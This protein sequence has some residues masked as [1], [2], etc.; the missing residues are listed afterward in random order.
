MKNYLTRQKKLILALNN[1]KNFFLNN[2]F[3]LS[4]I[5]A[6]SLSF[7][8]Y[9]GFR[10]VFPIDSFLIF[11]SG[12]NVSNNIHP[13]KDYW[14]ITGPV[15]D[16]L[17]A[18]FFFIFGFN[19]HSYVLHA[20]ILNTILSIS[21]FY[22]FKSFNVNIFFSTIFAISVGIL[23]YPSIGT[24]FVD[25]H[26]TIFCTLSVSFAILGLINNKSK[27]W[28][29]SSL[30]IVLAFF[31]KQVPSAY[32]LIF[33]ISTLF[34]KYFFIQKD[35][36]ALYFFY[37][38]LFGLLIFFLIL[39]LFNI[40]FQNFLI[41]YILYPLSIGESRFENLN[42]DLKNTVFQF[43]YI[44]FALLP[45][46]IVFTLLKKKKLKK[47]N[48]EDLLIAFIVLCKVFIFIY[49]Q[50]LTKNQVLIFYLVPWCLGFSYY[51]I[52]KYYNK[53]FNN[54]FIVFFLIIATVKYHI[55]FNVE[56]KFMELSTANFNISVNGNNLD[57]SLSGLSWVSPIF[58]TDPSLE[59][60]LLKQT[61]NIIIKDMKNKIIITNYQILPMITKNLNYAP[62]KWFD[63]LSEPKK[64]NEYFK[65]Y[66]NFFFKS[67][68]LQNIK[69][70]YLVGGENQVT[71]FKKM[72]GKKD[73]L[74]LKKI[75]QITTKINIESCKL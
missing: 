1:T 26:A 14:S 73:C 52:S 22:L 59:L 56:K 31:S 72:F 34:I 3:C 54:Y 50:L 8:F 33:L 67:L 20:A 38:L 55:R 4:L 45:T 51:Y 66:Q 9:S 16:Y 63:D 57:K 39:I 71:A 48:K 13:F 42:V 44:Y 17:Q 53:S 69:N 30:L 43:K 29:I 18:I 25:H 10:G 23:A 15:L 2:Y 47:K 6:I 36:S 24:P 64:K 32:I 21:I 65:I 7:T 12:Y 28:I 70:I 37:G 62:N 46:L 19:W 75:N 68:I 35:K 74:Y 58:I 49:S 60:S 41:Q 61:K 5:I 27:F 11:N 40:P